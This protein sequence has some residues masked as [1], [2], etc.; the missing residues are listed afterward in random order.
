SFVTP[1]FSNNLA[2]SRNHKLFDSTSDTVFDSTFSSD[3]EISRNIQLYTD[4]LKSNTP[5]IKTTD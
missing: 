1:N 4:T 2:V 5:V 3:E